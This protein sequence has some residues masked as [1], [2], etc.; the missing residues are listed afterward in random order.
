[1]GLIIN[2]P[3]LEVKMQILFRGGYGRMAEKLLK[4]PLV[5]APPE[6]VGCEAVP[7]HMGVKA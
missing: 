4:A 3:K 1:M 6:E 5:H 2:V 7:Q